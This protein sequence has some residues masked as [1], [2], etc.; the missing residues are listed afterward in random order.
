M[1][2]SLCLLLVVVMLVG[3]APAVMAAGSAYM[4]GPD[5]VR[6]GDTIKVSFA[7]GGGIYGGSG[8]LSY[9]S[10]I[11]TLQGCSAAIGG[12]W[13]VE[14]NGNKFVFYDNSMSSPI[15]NSVIFTATFLVS[16]S[17]AEGTKISVSASGVTLSDGDKDMPMGTVTYST[18]IAKP[19]STDCSLAAM[20][21]SNAKI[22]PAFSPDVLN[23]SASVPFTTSSLKVDAKAAHSGAKVK[24]EN[25]AL[26][27]GNTTSVKV[28]V[29]AESGATKTY[30]IRVTRAQDPNYVPSDNADLKT[31]SVDGYTLSPVFAPEQTQYYVWLP[32]EAE[33]VTVKATVADKKAKLE[34]GKLSELIPGQGNDVLVTVTAEN[35]DKQVYTV[36][37]VRAPAHDKVK[38]F[39]M[40]TPEP[41][42]PTVPETEPTEEPTVE[43]TTEP[44][45]AP[46]TVPATQPATDPTEPMTGTQT[47][48]PVLTL[49]LLLAIAAGCILVGIAVGVISRAG[50]KKKK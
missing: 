24:V 15:N 37:V 23:Y 21:V 30:V 31:L 10:S 19:L 25:T 41:T 38:D 39:L 36:T 8:T 34:I 32:Y 49:P 5:V 2:R 12:S 27:A 48:G 18:T 40:G 11:L 35:G 26:A 46:T 7:A 6:A 33:S 3:L 22:S 20:T 28:T 50:T 47:L 14:F 4:S 45:V 9:D 16:A 29:T 42:Q 1:K 17:V 43:P 44:T 13:A